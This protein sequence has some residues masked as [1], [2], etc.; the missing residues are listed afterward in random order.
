[1]KFKLLLSLCVAGASLS[2]TAQGYKDGIEYYKADQFDNAKELLLRNIDDAETDKAISFYYLGCIAMKEGNIEEATKYF[3]DGIAANPEYAYNY[4]GLGAI[5]LKNNDVKAAEKNFKQAEKLTKK[6]ASI[7]IVIARAYYD[8]DP[9]AFAK[10]IAKRVDKARRTN[11][12][13]ADIY[14]FEGDMA[15]DMKDWGSAAGK[16]EMATSFETNATEGYVKGANMYF[17]INPAYSIELLKKLL[18]LNPTSALGQRELANKYYD[19][20]KFKEAVVEYEKYVQNPNHFKQDEDRFAFLLFYSGDYKKGYEFA[21]ALLQENSENFTARRFQFMNAAQLHELKDQLI[22]M[23]DALIA[24][25]SETNKFAPIDYSLISE[26]YKTAGRIDDAINVLN[27]AIAI[28][29]QEINFHKQLSMV[30]LEKGD[31]TNVVESFRNYIEKKQEPTPTDVVQYARF[32]YYG[33]IN[34]KTTNPEKSNELFAEATRI[35]TE[36]CQKYPASHIGYKLIGDIKVQQADA[37]D[38]SM[39]N[40]VALDDYLKAIQVLEENNAVTKNI[41][42]AQALYSYIGNYYLLEVK[43][44]ENAKEFYYKMLNLDPENTALR[45]Y[46]ESLK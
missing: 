40:S 37:A 8:A 10:E 30:Y 36:F 7:Q 12:E 38:T 1:M 25:H 13:E 20:N 31:W 18:E 11:M 39:I 24:A 26:E 44:V 46:I 2:A 23:A 17:Q 19:N 41:K 6:D 45:E 14:M 32:C 35:A 3:N 15:A 42:D 4:V 16:Y 43:D 21:T 28:I 34:H 29:P 33:A 9:V 22:P 5:N 27:E